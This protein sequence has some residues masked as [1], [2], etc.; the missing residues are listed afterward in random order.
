MRK[1]SNGKQYILPAFFFFLGLT[2]CTY[3]KPASVNTLVL[4]WPGSYASEDWP[5]VEKGLAWSLSF[6]GADLPRGSIN[7]VFKREGAD[8]ILFNPDRAGFHAEALLK[9][10]ALMIVL[11]E[12]DEY[13]QKQAVDLGRFLMLCVY[14]SYHYYAITGAEPTLSAFRNQFSSPDDRQ[15]VST[16][17]GVSSGDRLI[18][19]H[20]DKDIGAMYFMAEEGTGSVSAGTFIPKSYEVITI[21]SNGQP[22]FSLYDEQGNLKDAADSSRSIA[23]KPGKCMWCHESNFLPLFSFNPDVPGYLSSA[24]FI[25][26]VDSARIFLSAYRST[27][28][29]EIKYAN[30]QDHASGEWLYT[31]FMEPTV[32]RLSHE[33][34]MP[35]EEVR[36]L[37]KALQTHNNPEFTFAN[38]LFDRI[39]TDPFAP[40]ASVPVPFSVREKSMYEPDFFHIHQ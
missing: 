7:F 13:R 2:G 35:E 38:D 11:K 29:G 23:G 25:A 9:I 20:L 1:G 4:S 5:T 30:L 6:L 36:N 16:N 18:T 24:A 34:N 27:L 37:L 10:R 19:F 28:E 17:S 26:C 14:S 15:Y 3:E 31:G 39:H 32:Y 8:R 40:F 12:S 21:M 33:W 22:R